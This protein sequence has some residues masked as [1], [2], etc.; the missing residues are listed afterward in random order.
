MSEGLRTVTAVAGQKVLVLSALYPSDA[1]PG[2]G[3]FVRDQMVEIARRHSVTVVA[4]LAAKGPDERAR[5]ALV[6]VESEEDGLRVV[7]PRVLPKN[8]PG[9]R[10]I[11]PPIWAMKLRPVLRE[12]NLRLQGANLLHAQFGNEGGFAASRFA[13][14]ERLPFVLTVRGSDILI[15]GSR[16]VSRWFVAATVRQASA[17]IAVSRQLADR[18]VELGADRGRVTVIPGGVPYPPKLNRGEA[19]ASLGIDERET[20]VLW[21][22]GLLPVKQPLHMIAA[23]RE[24]SAPRSRLVMA[25]DGALRGEVEAFVRREGLED[26]VMLTGHLDRDRVWTW[27]SAADILVNSSRSEGTPFAVL[28]ALG[29][30]T[31]VAGYPLAGVSDALALVGGGQVADGVSPQALASA[32]AATI[33]DHRDRDE[34]AARARAQFSVEPVASQVEEI[35]SAVAAADG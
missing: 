10:A 1:Y 13:K 31:P 4:P 20:L 26:R 23:F 16:H 22:G 24:V 5:I 21:V 30:G 28:E 3:P 35:Y 8:L 2:S 9:G 14:H 34:L 6:P 15:S 11:G 33:R 29:A 7:R 19:R 27:Q 17:V 12:E 18:V 25:G 32:I